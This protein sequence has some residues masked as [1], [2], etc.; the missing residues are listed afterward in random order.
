LLGTAVSE[1][2]NQWRQTTS[3]EAG[4]QRRRHC[5]KG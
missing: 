2:G 5:S 3:Q 1:S 4:A